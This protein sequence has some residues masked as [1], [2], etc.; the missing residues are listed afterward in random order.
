MEIIKDLSE[1]RQFSAAARKAGE[2]IVLVPTMGFLHDGHRELL[3]LGAALG[4]RLVLSIFVNPAQF[5][6]NEDFSQYPRDLTG[7][8]DVARGEGVDAVFTPDA[9]DIYPEGFRTFVNVE[10]LGE[11][12]CGASRPGHF[13]GVATVVLK[14]FNIVSPHK[15]VFGK[16]DFQQLKII[17]KITED[18]DLQIEII[19]AA[20]VREADGLAMSSRNAYLTEDQRRAA[21]A[22][23]RALEAAKKAYEAGERDG[24][25]LMEMVGSVIGSEDTTEIEYVKC[26]DPETLKDMKKLDGPAV[27]AV[28]VRLGAARL[29]DNVELGL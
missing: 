11:N 22:I 5:G 15:A 12:L 24:A 27:I 20:T 23:P 9:S 1:M 17:K 13:R 26:V 4:S 19:E 14:L 18:L 8:L 28:A 3:R 10:G 16:K 25:A 29:I 21:A 2:T 7:D 6:V